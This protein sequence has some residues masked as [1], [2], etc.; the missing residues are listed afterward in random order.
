MK[1]GLR[2]RRRKQSSKTEKLRK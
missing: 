2:R 1:T